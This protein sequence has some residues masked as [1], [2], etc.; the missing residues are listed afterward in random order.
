M[1]ARRER[2]ESVM[3]DQVTVEPL[4]SFQDARGLVFE[5][6]SAGELQSQRNVHVVIT[7]PGQ[8][9]GNHFHE[10]G[11]EITVLIGPALLRYREADEVRD[12]VFQEGEVVKVSIPAKTAHAFQ[13]TGNRPMLLIGFNTVAHDQA[14]PDVVADVLIPP[15]S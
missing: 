2:D 11:N 8:V 9:R 6:V 7:E 12:I 14:R 10:R 5:P 4:K 15:P 1:D 13:N 3:A